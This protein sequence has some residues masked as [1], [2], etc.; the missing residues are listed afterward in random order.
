MCTRILF[1]IFMLIGAGCGCASAQ[2]RA[3]NDSIVLESFDTPS[4]RINPY[5]E[6]MM[7][8]SMPAIRQP[9]PDYSSN[10]LPPDAT[11]DIYQKIYLPQQWV[12]AGNYIRP[13]GSF[14]QGGYFSPTTELQ[15]AVLKTNGSFQLRTYG[16]YNLDGYKIPNHSALPWERNGFIGGMEMKFNNKFQIRVEVQRRNNWGYWN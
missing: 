14:W 6:F 2:S 12:P 10:M 1:L 5:G 11:K 7:N 13:E 4:F 15:S 3:E 8:I 9:M 16:Q